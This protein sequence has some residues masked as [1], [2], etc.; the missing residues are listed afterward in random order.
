MTR[1]IILAAGLGTRLRPVTS[2]KP[3]ALVH[4]NGIPLLDY[5]VKHCRYYGVRDIIINVH[6][7]PE[8]I[9]DHVRKNNSYGIRIE[10]SDERNELLETGGGIMKAAWFFEGCKN[11]LAYN[12][13]IL[14]DLHIGNLIA[15]H[16]SQSSV[17][18]LAVRNRKTSRY[19]LIDQS[20][21][22]VGWKNM[23][24]NETLIKVVPHSRIKPLGFSGIQVLSPSILPLLSKYPARFSIMDAYIG[25]CKDHCIMSYQHDDGFWMDIGKLDMLAEADRVLSER[26]FLSESFH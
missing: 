18:T 12:V 11:I 22:M 4:V 3:K 14:S 13:D 5:A 21:R 20:R 15:Y 2:E 26:N 8:M 9:I 1:A 24:T 7:F 10:F 23:A 25:V 19:I 16:E 17:A 6:H